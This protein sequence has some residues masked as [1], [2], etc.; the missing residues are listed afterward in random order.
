MHSVLAYPVNLE[1]FARATRSPDFEPEGTFA[2]VA[3]TLHPRCAPEFSEAYRAIA[4]ASA[5]L[6]NGGGDVMRPKIRCRPFRERLDEL[7]RAHAEMVRAAAAAER[8]AALALDASAEFEREIWKYSRDVVSGI[9]EYVESSA[10]SG[11]ERGRRGSAAIA[12]IDA[13]LVQLHA[14]G[15]AA[16]DS[17]ASWDLEWI[18]E[19]W[20][21]GLR[22]RFDAL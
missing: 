9:V 19:V 16:G 3:S 8:I 1:T 20:L 4:R 7:K 5:S 22:R 11:A 15:T 21:D 6:L 12:A 17:W 14:G 18:R 2:D 10:A 13:A